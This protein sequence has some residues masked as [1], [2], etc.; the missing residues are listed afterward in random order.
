[1]LEKLL[2]GVHAHE[3]PA[4]LCKCEGITW[5]L[6]NAVLASMLVLLI[7]VLPA[8]IAHTLAG[9]FGGRVAIRKNSISIS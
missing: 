6:W 9:S 5:A 1:M 8:S 2:Q 7:G 3:P 4:S